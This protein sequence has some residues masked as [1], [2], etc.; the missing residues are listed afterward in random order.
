MSFFDREQRSKVLKEALLLFLLAWNQV[1]KMLQIEQKMLANKIRF[2]ANKKCSGKN[3]VPNQTK[4]T[5][6]GTKNFRER[7]LL[8]IKQKVVSSK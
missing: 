3:F 6:K 1:K 2:K 4:Y 8:Q 5:T 7:K